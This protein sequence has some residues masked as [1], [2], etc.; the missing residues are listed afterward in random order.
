MEHIIFH[1]ILNHLNRY[2]IINPNQYGFKPGLSCQTQLALLVNEIL[3]ATD[4]GIK[5]ISCYL[6]SPKP[7]IQLLITNFYLR[8]WDRYSLFTIIFGGVIIVLA[9]KSIMTCSLTLLSVSVII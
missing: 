4:V 9:N 6:I 2:N 3:K 8:L 7:S 5:W 1:S